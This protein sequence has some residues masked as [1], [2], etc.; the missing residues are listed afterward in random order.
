MPSS[1]RPNPGWQ[2]G[3]APGARPL[4]PGRNSGQRTRRRSRCRSDAWNAGRRVLRQLGSASA[5]GLL[6]SINCPWQPTRAPK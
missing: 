6:L 5:A 1:M 2:L 3:S 4:P